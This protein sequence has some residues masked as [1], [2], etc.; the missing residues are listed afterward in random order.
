MFHKI[1]KA[2][3]AALATPLIAAAG[4][5]EVGGRAFQGH[6]VTCDLPGDRHMK[7]IGS[8]LDGSGMCVFTSAEHSAD[9]QGMNGWNGFRNWC[10]ERYP[11][12]GYPKKL[13]A[14]IL[15]YTKAKG[16]PEPRFVQYEGDTPEA[17]LE[18]CDLTGRCPAIA[19]GY[20]PRYGGSAMN[21]MVNIARFGAPS[22]VLD[23]NFP[24]AERYEWMSRGELVTR[25]KTGADS[26]GKPIRTNAWVFVW[27]NPSP[28]PIPRNEAPMNKF[29]PLFAAALIAQQ[30]PP[31]TAKPT[32]PTIAGTVERI[33]CVSGFCRKVTYEWV[34]FPGHENRLYLRRDSAILGGW[35]RT[36]R[37]YR[38]YDAFRGTWSPPRNEPP[39]PP[40]AQ[41]MAVADPGEK[42]PL[43]DAAS[44][45]TSE[46][47]HG[48]DRTNMPAIPK[49]RYTINGREVP[50]Y[51]VFTELGADMLSDDSKK[52]W[53][54]VLGTQ[55]EQQA[56]IDAWNGPDSEELR[57]HVRLWCSAKNH[58]ATDDEGFCPTGTP[59]ISWQ[60]ADGRVLYRQTKFAGAEQLRATTRAALRK[61]NPNYDPTKDPDPLA[62][63]PAV[64]APKPEEPAD[65]PPP[66]ATPPATPLAWLLTA[67]AG[68]FAAV[69]FLRT[70]KRN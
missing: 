9:W 63:K 65:P 50:S 42:P 41:P 58:W 37:Q 25:M 38:D 18:L 15:A 31:E 7:N 45:L 55:A 64:P 60:A 22:A 48:V 28:P 17:I 12:G 61:A 13:A 59:H 67:L 40:P 36:A 19:Y 43:G 10:A 32:G 69:A 11:G 6:E 68:I 3:L 56:V 29:L 20:S 70:P 8:K 34:E 66:A 21:H 26:F 53:L 35:N 52:A 4:P 16:L 30:P 51:Q 62:P 14:L 47:N 46:N 27:L 49:E 39:V 23:N 44:P 33:E 5:S 54:V 2:A 1:H 24:G 57:P